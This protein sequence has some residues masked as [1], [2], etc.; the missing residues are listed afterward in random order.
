MGTLAI[1][2]PALMEAYNPGE[3]FLFL[4]AAELDLG[5]AEDLKS[6]IYVRIFVVLSR[7]FSQWGLERTKPT[8]AGRKTAGGRHGK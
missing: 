4:I 2:T 5:A 8:P 1:P 6:K 3:S 7:V